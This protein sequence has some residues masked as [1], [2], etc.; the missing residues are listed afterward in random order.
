MAVA[1]VMQLTDV[2]DRMAAALAPTS[3]DEPDVIRDYVDAVQP[4]AL[5]LV[6]GD[7]WLTP[8]VGAATTFGPCL[9]VARAQILAI[10]WRVDV[11]PGVDK[12]EELVSYAI[13]RLQADETYTWPVATLEAPREF[14]VGGV[15]LLGAYINYDVSVTV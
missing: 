4:P 3:P 15:R 1:T 11:G 9:W 13:T 8:G 7:P 14:P 2:R 10:A 6:W 12:L 5:M